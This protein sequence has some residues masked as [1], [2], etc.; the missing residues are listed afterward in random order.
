MSEHRI[1]E[2]LE[3]RQLICRLID[4]PIMYSLGLNCIIAQFD[5][6]ALRTGGQAVSR[7]PFRFRDVGLEAS[8]SDWSVQQR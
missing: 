7:A 3:E 8:L 6:S 5:I 1:R 2:R 4:Y